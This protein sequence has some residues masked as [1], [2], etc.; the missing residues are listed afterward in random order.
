MEVENERSH[1]DEV[2]SPASTP[3]AFTPPGEFGAKSSSEQ[4][5]QTLFLVRWKSI[6]QPKFVPLLSALSQTVAARSLLLSQV[7]QP[8]LLLGAGAREITIFSLDQ[9]GRS[10]HEEICRAYPVDFSLMIGVYTVCHPV[11]IYYSQIYTFLPVLM[12]GKQM[13]KAED[14]CLLGSPSLEQ[15]H[16]QCHTD[17]LPLNLVG[18]MSKVWENGDVQVVQYPCN[19][20]ENVYPMDRMPKDIIPGDLGELVF[21]PVYDA[22][23]GSSTQG[24]LAVIEL[25][26]RRR[27]SDAMI[28]A[29]LI[30]TVA[31]I[32][33]SLGL[34]L[35]A[36]ESKSYS[37]NRCDMRNV[38]SFQSNN[39]M[40]EDSF[41]VQQRTGQGMCR[42]I[43]HRNLTD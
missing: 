39:R 15:F 23:P 28:V 31:E 10:R 40:W 42:T 37:R 38:S 20:P 33:G 29:T 8:G 41:D 27:T 34:S 30:S 35:S 5:S 9:G 12:E 36:P 24:I 7:R 4:S 19:L 26:I 43:S 6:I 18:P 17:G 11:A 14:V 22:E 25:M 3:I 21:L 2:G 13:L 16:Q 32:M 1:I